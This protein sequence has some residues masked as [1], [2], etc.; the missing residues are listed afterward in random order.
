MKGTK[1]YKRVYR[2]RLLGLYKVNL[3][4][5]TCEAHELWFGILDKPQ[6]ISY[7]TDVRGTDITGGHLTKISYKEY[8]IERV[9]MA[10][11]HD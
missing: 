8:K 9:R 5:N 6:I 7:Q 11:E 1:Y 3:D 4:L 2:S 10:L